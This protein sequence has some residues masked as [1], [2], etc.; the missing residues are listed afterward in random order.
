MGGN[1]SPFVFL[2]GGA[3]FFLSRLNSMNSPQSNSSSGRKTVQLLVFA[4][5]VLAFANP[6]VLA[7]FLP[8]G[9]HISV[10]DPR[11]LYS[12]GL[13]PPFPLTK[14]QVFHPN[15]DQVM[16]RWAKHNSARRIRSVEIG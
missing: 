7:E 2:R 15:V 3:E 6:T 8:P 4:V 12:G 5:A 16:A 14:S 11:A 10:D 1:G 9:N 13:G